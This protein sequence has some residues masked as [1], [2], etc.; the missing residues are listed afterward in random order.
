ML[1]GSLLTQLHACLIIHIY[2]CLPFL[3][4]LQHMGEQLGI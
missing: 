4:L 3:Q 2:L 1:S